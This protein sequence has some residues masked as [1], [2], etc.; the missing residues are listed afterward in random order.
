MADASPRTTALDVAGT[1]GFS[2][3]KHEVDSVDEE[4]PLLRDTRIRL[5]RQYEKC[6]QSGFD[7]TGQQEQYRIALAHNK[8]QIKGNLIYVDQCYFANKRFVESNAI[9]FIFM[10][11]RKRLGDLQVKLARIRKEWEGFLE[12]R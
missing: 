5:E 6:C 12:Y 11:E 8:G 7:T 3:Q 2:K 4:L 9:G 1:T 10:E